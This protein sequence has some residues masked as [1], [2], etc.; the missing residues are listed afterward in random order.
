MIYCEAM[1]RQQRKGIGDEH[2]WCLDR[3]LGSKFSGIRSRRAENCTA[4]FCLMEWISELSLDEKINKGNNGRTKSKK[5]AGV[6]E[7][8]SNVF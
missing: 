7:K 8:L 1:C 2:S 3:R 5:M 6:H 4:M